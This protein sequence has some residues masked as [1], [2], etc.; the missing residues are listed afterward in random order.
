VLI[1][2]FFMRIRALNWSIVSGIDDQ[3]LVVI[4]RNDGLRKNAGQVAKLS[5]GQLGSAGGHKS[6]ARAEI[7]LA[8]LKP[9]VACREDEKMSR[10]I[11]R[12]IQT[13][14]HNRKRS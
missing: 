6:M 7:D 10:W 9:L 1:A 5:F 13:R 3:K 8:N 4:F 11:I 12:Q 14:S 2:D